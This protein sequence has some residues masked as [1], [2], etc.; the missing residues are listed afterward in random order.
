MMDTMMKRVIS[1][2][3]AFVLLLGLCTAALA[4]GVKA[5]AVV[6]DSAKGSV[7]VQ[8]K[9]AAG[10]GSAHGR[11]TCQLPDGLVLVSAKSLLGSSGIG[12]L[13]VTKDSFSFAWACYGDFKTQTPVLELT[14][15]GK[16]GAYTLTFQ[17]PEG[18]DAFTAKVNLTAAFD[19]VQDPGAWFYD[20]VYEAYGLGLM[21]GKEA[22][23][24]APGETM[25]RAML[26]TALYRLAGSPAVSGK[27]PYSD[28]AKGSYFEKAVI[29]GTQTGVVNGTGDGKFEPG[30]VVT[31]QQAVTMFYRYA[32]KIAKISTGSRADLSGYSDAAQVSAYALTAMRW[33]VGAGMVNGFPD[34]TLQP[35]GTLNRAQAAKLLV[36]LAN[37][38]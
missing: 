4:A 33:A 10:K 21:N 2:L 7:T 32:V 5:T 16:P 38:I 11:V 14:V 6:A 29:W 27:N 22:N 24:F 37:Q 3:M 13:A 23:L 34:G 26:I 8:V 25:N 1:C 17:Q 30:A 20:A 36:W 9:I 35:N 19:D 28:V 15:S 12:D 31:R 18:G